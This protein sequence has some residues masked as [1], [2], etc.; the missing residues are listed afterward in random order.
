LEVT[1]TATIDTTGRPQS[2]DGVGADG[3]APWNDLVAG[4]AE[5]S[6]EVVEYTY[7]SPLV[8]ASDALADYARPSFA[9][10]RPVGEAVA[11]LRS[12]IFD[13]FEF[14]PVATDVDTPLE[15]VME[16][17]RG[18]CQDFAHVMIGCLRSMGL[19]ARYLSGY[20]ETV[21][22]PGQERLVGADR[23]H[24]WVG[25]HLGAGRWIGEDPTNDQVA[26]P[27][28]I[29]TAVGRDYRDVPPLKGVIFT[30]ATESS[31]TV[32]VDVAPE[33]APEAT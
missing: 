32:S 14:D 15:K 25:V 18:V 12:R 22:P 23:T 26:G 11:E 20:L 17:R 21:P 24:A 16:L 9:D 10:G 28:Y 27:R 33:P 29:T 5:A 3:E 1:S 13:E 19:A 31:L 4:G 8:K 30:D 7:D 6:I 2:I